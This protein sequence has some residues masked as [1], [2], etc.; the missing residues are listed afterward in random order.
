MNIGIYG[1]SFNP[2]H[3]GH[4]IVLE[5]VQDQL[6]FD[7]VLFIPAAS[8]PHKND[9]TLAPAAE[10]LEMTRLAI[11]GNAA[12]QASDI[13]IRRDGRSYSIDT[14]DSLAAEHPGDKFSLIIGADNF[15]EFET[16]KSAREIL[17]K[18]E[19]VVMNREGFSA[20]PEKS[21]FVRMVRFVHVPNIG[22][23]ST[24]IRRRV[25]LGR[26]IRYLVPQSVE[27]H[28]R[29]KGLYRN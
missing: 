13:E 18:A 17:T 25:K 14:L 8:P 5:S 2:P 12:F 7:K 27:N 21:E 26:S 23:S 29:R 20:H 15:L 6:R 4:L 19:V 11:E 24:D 22:I 10:R 16:W 3:F 1:G 28:I 9:P